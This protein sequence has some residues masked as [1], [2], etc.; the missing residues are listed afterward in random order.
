MSFLKHFKIGERQDVRFAADFFN[1]WNHTNFGD[2]S[3][4]DIEAYLASP[5]N[6]RS[7]RS[8]GLTATRG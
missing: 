4:T 1:L 2:P 3:V 5:G 8:W 6:N 7:G